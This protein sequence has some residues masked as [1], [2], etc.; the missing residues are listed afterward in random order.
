M[1]STC[2]LE[3]APSV[4]FLSVQ[5]VNGRSECMNEWVHRF[6]LSFQVSNVSWE[7][8]SYWTLYWLKSS[9]KSKESA[10]PHLLPSDSIS[11]INKI[12]IQIYEGPLWKQLECGLELLD[13]GFGYQDIEGFLFMQITWVPPYI[14]PSSRWNAKQLC[15]L[16]GVWSEIK[17]TQYNHRDKHITIL[18]CFYCQSNMF[19]FRTP[20]FSNFHLFCYKCLFLLINKT[21]CMHLWCGHYDNFPVK[22]SKVD[23]KSKESGWIS[24]VSCGY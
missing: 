19:G 11:R 22:P 18:I 14:L 12:C 6:A 17:E 7:T 1:H 8:L 21:R 10:Q 24:S 2:S 5:F 16:S 23:P 3:I 15:C 13:V 9:K 20:I 4:Q